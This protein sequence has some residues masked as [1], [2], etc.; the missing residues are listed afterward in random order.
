MTEKL[1]AVNISIFQKTKTCEN[2]AIT[3]LQLT[4]YHLTST[5]ATN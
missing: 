5:F 1:K 3:S 2:I 4:S